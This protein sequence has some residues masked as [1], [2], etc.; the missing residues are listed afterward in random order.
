MQ[1]IPNTLVTNHFR[2]QVLIKGNSFS[3]FCKRNHVITVVRMH[4]CR[5]SV[6]KYRLPIH[7][8]PIIRANITYFIHFFNPESSVDLLLTI[9]N[10]KS[11]YNKVIES[12]IVVVGKPD[13]V[14]HPCGKKIY[15][16]GCCWWWVNSLNHQLGR[17][18]GKHLKINRILMKMTL[19]RH[20]WHHCLLPFN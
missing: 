20:I 12:N 4:W 8:T 15:L 17:Y 14:S 5:N 3:N 18:S 19:L 16:F 13:D 1:P 10:C 7:T 2:F 6:N 11:M 9:C